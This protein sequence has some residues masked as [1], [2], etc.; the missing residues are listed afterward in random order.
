MADRKLTPPDLNP[1]ITRF[2]ESAAAGTL[3]IKRCRDCGEKHFYPRAHCPF[4]LSANTEWIEASGRGEI[5]AFSILRRV[6]IPY[7][8]AYVT[9]AEG[10]TMLTNIVDCDFERVSVGQPVQVIFKPTDGGPPV[11]MFTAIQGARA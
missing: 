1:E 8:A 11:P 4:C 7:I 6:P 10:P 3:L 9:L 5:Y 2:F